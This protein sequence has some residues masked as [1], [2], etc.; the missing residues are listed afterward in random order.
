M[1]LHVFNHYLN[2]AV[3]A[4]VWDPGLQQMLNVSPFGMRELPKAEQI[5]NLASGATNFGDHF[6]SFWELVSPQF[7]SD[8]AFGRG[9]PTEPL[10]I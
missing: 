8:L 9:E 3:N 1:C 7:L 5:H 2:N 6:F 4:Y 10:D